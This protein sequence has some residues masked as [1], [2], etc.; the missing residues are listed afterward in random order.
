MSCPATGVSGHTDSIRWL[1]RIIGESGI[2]H[3]FRMTDVTPL[4]ND[5]EHSFIRIQVP[6][7]SPHIVQPFI[8]KHA[9]VEG[10]R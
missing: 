3:L 7:G 5:N 4:L 6:F 1:I 8:A 9:L 2:D 10:L